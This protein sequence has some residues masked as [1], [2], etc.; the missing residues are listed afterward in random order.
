MA[1]H[2]PSIS[3]KSPGALEL[4]LQAAGLVKLMVDKNTTKP[5]D[6]FPHDENWLTKTA[7]QVTPKKEEKGGGLL[8]D[9]RF[10]VLPGCHC[11]HEKG[12]SRV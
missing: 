4:E 7:N 1:S 9:L 12:N 2:I 5:R 3:S 10:A 8:E 6:A 11:G